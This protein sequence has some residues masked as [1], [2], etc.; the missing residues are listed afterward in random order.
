MGSPWHDAPA[1]ATLGRRERPP[2]LL[3]RNSPM[4]AGGRHS[5]KSLRKG[6]VLQTLSEGRASHHRPQGLPDS[7]TF[8]CSPPAACMGTWQVPVT[9]TCLDPSHPCLSTEL[10]PTVTR[11]GWLLG[12]WGLPVTLY[13]TS[14]LYSPHSTLKTPC[15]SS[16][17]LEV[18]VC[19]SH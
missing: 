14:L 10:P 7:G 16:C 11:L 8:P 2:L 17:L 15:V 4:P 13:P 5:T 12:S 18:I 9:Q 19:R 3:P 1:A 6:Q